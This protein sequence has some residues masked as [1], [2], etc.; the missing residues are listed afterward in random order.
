MHTI[1]PARLKPGVTREAVRSAASAVEQEAS[2]A[3]IRGRALILWDLK[4]LGRTNELDAI[5]PEQIQPATAYLP[6]HPDPHNERGSGAAVG[7]PT[8]SAR[9]VGG[10]PNGLPGRGQRPTV[11]LNEG[12]CL[13]QILDWEWRGANHPGDPFQ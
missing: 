10:S 2:P 6:R 3:V 9:R 11:G 13:H 7:T 5:D 1:E 4:V 12:R 8:S